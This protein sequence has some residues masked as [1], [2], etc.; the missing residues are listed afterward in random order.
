MVQALSGRL[1]LKE[2]QFFNIR[3]S[4]NSFHVK[5]GDGETKQ[6]RE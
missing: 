2:V 5:K 1:L 4:P 6:K 3:Q